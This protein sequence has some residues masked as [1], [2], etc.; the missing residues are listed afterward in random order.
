MITYCIASIFLLLT[1]TDLAHHLHGLLV[2]HPARREPHTHQD[3]PPSTLAGGSGATAGGGA[4]SSAPPSL[5][6]DRQAT[7]GCECIVAA[8]KT[9]DAQPATQP[10]G[11]TPAAGHFN[12]G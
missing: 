2:G 4:G 9:A 10:A 7:L 11:S 8:T 5:A 1:L 3:G 12:Y 6:L